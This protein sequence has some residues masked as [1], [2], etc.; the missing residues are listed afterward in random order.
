MFICDCPICGKTIR[1]ARR[2]EAQFRPFCSHR[3]KM[4]DLGRWLDGTYR[5]SEP[6]TDQAL[7]EE[8]A[9]GGDVKLPD[10]DGEETA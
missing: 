3:C 9:P 5:I 8:I 1:V 10:D 6:L 4:V 7:M 2:E